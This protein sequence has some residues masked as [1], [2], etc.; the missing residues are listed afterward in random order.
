MIRDPKS[1][2]LQ[3]RSSIIGNQNTRLSQAQCIDI[4]LPELI[5]K[6]NKVNNISYM[7]LNCRK[8]H[9]KFLEADKIYHIIMNFLKRSYILV[10][11][12]KKSIKR[13]ELDMKYMVK[14][15]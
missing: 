4:I 8:L 11:E 10:I 3:A 15:F 14:D 9:N 7:L 2:F 6:V 5:D 12:L 1:S 13:R